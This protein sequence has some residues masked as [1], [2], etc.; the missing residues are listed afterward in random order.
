MGNFMFFGTLSLLLINVRTRSDAR[1]RHLHHGSWGLKALAWV[2]CNVLP[3]FFPTGA[4]EAYTW[5]ARLGSGVF[6]VVQMVI[7]LDFAFFWNESWVARSAVAWVVGLLASTVALYG[8][9][10]TLLVFLYKWYSPAGEECSRNVWLITTTL[11]A[12]I[13]F[14][15]LC[16]HPVAK[17]G[18][19]LP[20][21]VSAPS[22]PP[23]PSPSFYPSPTSSP[24]PSFSPSPFPSRVACFPVNFTLLP[25]VTSLRI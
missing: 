10:I 5:L 12:C 6:L 7:L 9:S 25:C 11:V 18:S 23:S 16:M 22:C 8:G 1:D 2:V 14:T 15:G 3:F 20:S 19:L 21:A 13:V 17:E 24:S 4:I